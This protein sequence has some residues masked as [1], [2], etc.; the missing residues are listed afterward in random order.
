MKVMQ[1]EQ[2]FAS[3]ARFNSQPR[4]RLPRDESWRFCKHSISR[5]NF[6]GTTAG[7]AGLFLASSK[8]SPVMGASCA[9]PR[10]IPQGNQFLFPDPTVFHIELPG[11][12]GFPDNDPARNDPSVITDFNGHIGLAYVRGTGTHT[13]LTTGMSSNLPFEVDLRFMEGTYVGLDGRNHHGAF[14]LI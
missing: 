10:P 4:V 7:A 6:L 12:P 11:F 2:R 1:T 9:D 5:R 3:L 13:D 8:L 14:A